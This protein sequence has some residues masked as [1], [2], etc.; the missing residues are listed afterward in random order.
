MPT[1]HVNYFIKV[2]DNKT[3]M[4]WNEILVSDI[5]T[6]SQRLKYDQV[7]LSWADWSTSSK[8]TQI[9]QKW[10]AQSEKKK[11]LN[12]VGNTI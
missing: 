12:W 8:C 2:D 3:R 6:L 5:M 1:L 10:F 7:W 11:D 4:K 9:K